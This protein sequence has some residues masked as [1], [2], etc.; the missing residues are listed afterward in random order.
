MLKLA[1]Q[2]LITLSLTHTRLI[3]HTHASLD[4]FLPE[5]LHRVQFYGFYFFLY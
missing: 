2:R 4:V 3:S 5:K 1:G